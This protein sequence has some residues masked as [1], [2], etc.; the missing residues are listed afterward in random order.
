MEALRGRELT[1]EQPRRT[2]RGV[3]STSGL[4]IRPAAHLSLGRR[5]MRPAA[6]GGRTVEP[7]TK[8]DL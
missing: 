1:R 8:E 7:V 6:S 2:F 5:A 3:P 4:A